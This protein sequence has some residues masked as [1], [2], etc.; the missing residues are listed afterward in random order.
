MGVMVY[1]RMR[2]TYRLAADAVG[3]SHVTLWR[4]EMEVGN[5]ALPVA[6]LFGVLRSSGV[7]GVDEKWVLVPKND[8]P[9]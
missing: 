4:W 3:V 8:K 5:Q 1:M 7:V 2:T 6:A 9:R